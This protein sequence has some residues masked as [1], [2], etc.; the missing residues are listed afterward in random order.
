MRDR[1]RFEDDARLP[2]VDH[3]GLVAWTAEH[4]DVEEAVASAV[5]AIELEYMVAI[6][7]ALISPNQF[8]FRFYDP[9]DLASAPRS[10]DTLRLARDAE[11]LAN[12]PEELAHRVFEAELQFSEMRGMA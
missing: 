8:E 2:Y 1:D 11:R 4:A 5:L 3:D 12:V 7:I 10:I 6:G 9:L